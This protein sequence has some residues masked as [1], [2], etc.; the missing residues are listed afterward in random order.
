[1]QSWWLS[2]RL[3][4][5]PRY[6][7]MTYKDFLVPH[8]GIH[9][10][11]KK[12]FARTQGK[13]KS[14]HKHLLR[15]PP[16]QINKATIQANPHGQVTTLNSKLKQFDWTNRHN[17]RGECRAKMSTP[18]GHFGSASGSGRKDLIRLEWAVLGEKRFWETRHTHWSAREL[19]SRL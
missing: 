13:I 15:V 1:M 8:I 16:L 9:R 2:L 5:H 10:F 6:T 17:K 14:F 7:A 19:C 3:S 11:S 4:N 12:T 18:L